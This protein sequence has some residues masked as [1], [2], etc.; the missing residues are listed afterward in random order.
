MAKITIEECEHADICILCLGTNYPFCDKC[1]TGLKRI[2]LEMEY[3]EKGYPYSL[4]LGNA[5]QAKK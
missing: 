1:R 3:E 2:L 5:K 4:E